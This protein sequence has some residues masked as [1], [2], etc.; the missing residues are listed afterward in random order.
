M[1]SLRIV[2]IDTSA[3][4]LISHTAAL[5]VVG[6]EHSGAAVASRADA[7]ESRSRGRCN[8]LHHDVNSVHK[9]ISIQLLLC[10]VTESFALS[11]EKDYANRADDRAGG[12]FVTMILQHP[13]AISRRGDW[14]PPNGRVDLRLSQFRKS[15][16]S[17]ALPA[18]S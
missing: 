1:I 5:G 12:L 17:S 2:R 6:R 7:T 8:F 11:V 18:P 15:K 14:W 10:L 16:K 3:A 9:Y 13:V 4:Y